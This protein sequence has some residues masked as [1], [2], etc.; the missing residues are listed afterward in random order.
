MNRIERIKEME[1]HF[2]LFQAAVKGL[3]DALDSYED[4]LKSYQKV[5]AYFGSDQWLRDFEAD[6]AGKLPKDLK[7]GILSEDGAFDVLTENRAL[8][9]RM[10]RLM[11]DLMQ[12]GLL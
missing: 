1:E 9:I 7:R 10:M 11:T 4:A 5:D 12:K 8:Q 2:D 6:E 3:S